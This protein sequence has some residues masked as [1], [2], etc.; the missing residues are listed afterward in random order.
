M[1]HTTEATAVRFIHN[2]DYDGSV[3]IIRLDTNE[4]LVV[5][6]HDLKSLVADWVRGEIIR[7]SEHAQDDEV[8][9][10]Y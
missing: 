8:L 1:S 10:R 5:P 4:S 9:L 3:K 6:F 7:F 2:G